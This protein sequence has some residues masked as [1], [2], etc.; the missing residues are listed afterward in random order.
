MAL[1]PE[2]GCKV[3]RP[4]RIESVILLLEDRCKMQIERVSESM[5][6][7]AS[8]G[9]HYVLSVLRTWKTAS[10]AKERDMYH[11]PSSHAEGQRSQILSRLP[12]GLVL[13]LLLYSA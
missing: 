6:A 11:P 9:T 8:V 13:N 1:T 10:R 5:C 12:A 4:A 2:A 3:D 7:V